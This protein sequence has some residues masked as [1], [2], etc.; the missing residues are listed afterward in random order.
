MDTISLLD[1]N[2]CNLFVVYMFCENYRVLNYDKEY[3]M[4][5][6]TENRHC[7]MYCSRINKIIK[8]RAVSIS[9]HPVV[10]I[11]NKAVIVLWN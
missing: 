4:L 2:Q 3:Y 8:K 6:C 7:R 1:C 9:P 11:L 10:S 5:D